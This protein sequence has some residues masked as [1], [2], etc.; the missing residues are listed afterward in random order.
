MTQRC[1]E[2]LALFILSEDVCPF[3]KMRFLKHFLTL[4]PEQD[5][6][7]KYITVL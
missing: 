4:G 1:E 7:L 6:P 2:L 5:P 3:V